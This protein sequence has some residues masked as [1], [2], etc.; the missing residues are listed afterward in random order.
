MV[1]LD[2]ALNASLMLDNM[3]GFLDDQSR[4]FTASA[5]VSAP[6]NTSFVQQDNGSTLLSGGGPLTATLIGGDGIT[7][8]QSEVS[9]DAGECFGSSDDTESNIATAAIAAI[10]CN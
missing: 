8:G 5:S 2:G 10:P 9:I 1:N 7:S 6:A 4:G 3:V